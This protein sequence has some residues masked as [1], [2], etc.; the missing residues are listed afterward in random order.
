ML[1]DREM[2]TM[3]S[4]PLRLL[5]SFPRASHDPCRRH[6]VAGAVRTCYSRLMRPSTRIS[7]NV[8]PDIS[9]TTVA[10]GPPGVTDA[11]K[12]RS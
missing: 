6:V 2:P 9:S 8:S 1:S 10:P 11:V 7:R 4:N 3:G 5:T 12:G